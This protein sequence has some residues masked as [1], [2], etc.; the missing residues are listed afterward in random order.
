MKTK[1]Q[2]LTDQMIEE[3]YNYKGCKGLMIVI[4]FVGLLISVGVIYGIIELIK[5]IK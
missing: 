3:E 1:K 4:S 5:L 2:L